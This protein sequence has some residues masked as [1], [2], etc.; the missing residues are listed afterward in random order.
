MTLAPGLHPLV[1]G[2]PEPWAAEWGEDRHGPFMS[3]AVGDVVQ[4]LRW[5]PSGRFLMGS[6]EREAGR[7][8]DEGP[9]HEVTLSRGFWLA[10][11]PCTQVL[12]DAV[13]RSNPSRFVAPDRPV[14]CV[15][16]E[17]CQG[18][19][20]QLNELV[21]GLG[22]RLPGE[23][24]W[25]YACRAGTTGPTWGGKLG[26]IAWYRENSKQS[27]QPVR[28]KAPNPLG[29]YD[30]LGNVWEWCDDWFERYDAAPV[31]DPRGPASG[32]LRVVRGGS[33]LNFARLVRAALRRADDP[34]DRSGHLGFRLARGQ[35]PSQG[36]EP[37]PRS[38]PESR[39][40]GR[41]PQ[42]APER[43]ATAP[44]VPR[45]RRT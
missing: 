45:T 34:G 33:W 11:T 40:A 20:G 38:G 31:T 10:D 23:A 6:P 28:Q 44:G 24:E 17:D 35:G 26:D 36:A 18:F 4:R 1:D 12:W 19:L 37:R 2:L 30:M 29:L 13:M 8:G 7:W 41:A 5:V 42:A 39:G 21:P 43:D 15:S 27:T 14:E 16:W 9:Q 32:S 22:A 3:F 25:E